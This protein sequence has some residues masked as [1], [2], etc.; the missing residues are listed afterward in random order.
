[1]VNLQ[2]QLYGMPVRR[3]GVMLRKAFQYDMTGKNFCTS[4]HRQSLLA[5]YITR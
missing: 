1:M 3:K 2:I 4:C 5:Q